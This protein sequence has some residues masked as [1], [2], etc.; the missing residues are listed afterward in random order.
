MS[1][2][3]PKQLEGNRR[4]AQHS[5]GPR[6]GAGKQWVKFS[7]LKHGLLAH[8]SGGSSYR[9][10]EDMLV[11]KIAVSYWRL[12]RAL[13][14]ETG[15]ISGNIRNFRRYQFTD[16][17]ATLALP[18]SPD[19]LKIPRHKNAIELQP[20]RAINQLRSLQEH[21]GLSH[22]TPRRPCLSTKINKLPNKPI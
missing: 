18:S 12:R 4:N 1:G 22:L 7:A 15:E 20:H 9:V 10:L 16:Y 3:S 8:L 21:R 2:S 14:A 5:T 13:R 11:E 17:P 19:T 6:A